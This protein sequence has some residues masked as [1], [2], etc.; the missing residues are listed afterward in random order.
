MVWNTSM[1][2]RNIK[3]KWI[4]LGMCLV[5]FLSTF[6]SWA[7]MDFKYD[8]TFVE[9]CTYDD[10]VP[11]PD[12]ILGYP[13]GTQAATYQEMLNYFEALS[14]SCE[15]VQLFQY[16]ETHEGRKL[17]YLVVS[18][19]DNMRQLEAI[20]SKIRKLANPPGDS[21]KVEAASIIDKT[22][23]I[24]WLGY[25]IH[26]DELSSTDAAIW[27]AYQLAAGQD[28]VTKQICKETV[29]CI[30]PLQNPDGRER[31]LTQM[32]MFNGKVMNPDVQSA[33]H[34]GMWPWGRGNHYLFDL[35]RDFIIFSQ[36]ETVA[37]IKIWREY[38]PQIF[39]DSHEMGGL[40]T[41]LFSP[42][43]EPINPFLPPTLEKWSNVF[44]Q[45]QAAAFDKHGWSY[46]SREW[47]DNWYPGYT[48]WISYTGAI[49]ILYEQAG[50]DGSAIRRQD[51]SA[52][53]FR[54]SVHHHITSS[55]ANLHT[56]AQRRKEIMRDY[57][58]LKL[59]NI[60]PCGKDEI[61]AY[62]IE[63]GKN[64]SRDSQFIEHLQLQGIEVF[65][66]TKSLKMAQVSSRFGE[67]I[68][69]K[70]F[71]I[72]SWVVY[73][74]QQMKNL[75]NAVMEFDP[76]MTDEFLQQER[77]Y[78][79]KK[80]QSRLYDVSSWSMPIAHA[81]QC[82]S[83][84]MPVEIDRA[85]ESSLKIK[86][87]F[88]STVPAYGYVLDGDDDATTFAVSQLLEKG[89]AVRTAEK[90]F[91][92]AGR[93]FPRGSFLIRKVENRD[94]MNEIIKQIALKNKVHVYGA[95][96]ALDLDMVDL[97]GRYFGLLT[98]PR[99]A[100]AMGRGVNANSYGALWNLLDAK[101]QIRAS[102][103]NAEVLS[104]FDLRKYN[105]LILPS[106]TYEESVLPTLKQWVN[107]GGTLIA[108]DSAVSFFTKEKSDMSS[109]R[110]RIDVLDKLE[111]YEEAV[112]HEEN[113]LT[114]SASQKD[115]WDYRAED[116]KEATPVEKKDKLVK[117]KLKRIDAWERR[118]SPHGTFLKTKIDAYHWL[119]YG[120]NDPLAVM[121]G[122]GQSYL[123]KPPVETPV[124]FTDQ[125]SIRV[126]GLLWPEARRRFAKTAYLTRE[127]VGKGQVILFPFEPA[128]RGYYHETA[129]LLWNAI[130]LGPGLGAQTQIPW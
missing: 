47:L 63:P 125:A 37:R 2:I 12:K 58:T 121:V 126:S 5:M 44:A 71:P 24:G 79:E 19:P 7:A 30:D 82:Y 122:S 8:A 50:V 40:D 75:I 87:I 76:R 14:E 48:D 84:T 70:E 104:S 60:Q 51:G 91:N 56:L 109:V 1:M 99:I 54:E 25:S 20:K 108:L 35:N 52:M 4:M 94:G 105:V 106:G 110:E 10:S 59:N 18:S 127:S 112:E 118:F 69:D 72:G 114:A 55:L 117:E 28:E 31:F 120:V 11:N 62:I 77:F 113:A 3:S 128:F 66:T 16:G 39:V 41:Y 98:C 57:A 32:R 6:S 129:R 123:S 100:I 95:D 43:R 23:A 49:S 21:D 80:N 130:F 29:V 85:K 73:T 89:I 64:A 53:T 26:G 68:T 42:A 93:D 34:A 83:A 36:P 15:H 67:I 27:V 74:R 97:G 81:V 9:G 124:R 38:N 119:T 96:T 115:V 111:E 101:Y 88:P 13:V 102:S 33:N 46:Y 78:L 61:C 92:A 103:L 65:K 22:P 86:P 17:I 107:N 90:A 116:I 45:D